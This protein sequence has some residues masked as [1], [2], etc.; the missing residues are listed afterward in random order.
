MPSTSAENRTMRERIMIG[1]YHPR[2]RCYAL[3]MRGL[4]GGAL[5]VPALLVVASFTGCAST[6]TPP[7][8]MDDTDDTSDTSES[9]DT[10]PAPTTT[11][12]DAESSTTRIPETTSESDT[13]T[14][15]GDTT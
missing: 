14:D 15:A 3:E 4:H 11:T 13:T 10:T 2:D 1:S 9:D 6:V 5:S 12:S 7:D 8:D